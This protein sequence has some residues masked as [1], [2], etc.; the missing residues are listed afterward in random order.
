MKSNNTFT[1]N[2]RRETAVGSNGENPWSL[3]ERGVCENTAKSIMCSAEA[4]RVEISDGWS[5]R[6]GLEATACSEAPVSL[7]YKS[8]AENANYNT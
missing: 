3:K 2:N 8:Y 7:K 5:Q 6:F 1:N 4:G